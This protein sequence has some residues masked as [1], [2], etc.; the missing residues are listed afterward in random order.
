MSVQQVKAYPD[1]DREPDLSSDEEVS[2]MTEKG[3]NDSRV[4]SIEERT[5]SEDPGRRQLLV[6]STME[7]SSKLTLFG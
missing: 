2:S 3:L 6:S 1:N 4:D 7:R 5:G